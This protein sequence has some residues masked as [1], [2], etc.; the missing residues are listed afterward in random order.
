[1]NIVK[2]TIEQHFKAL[3]VPTFACFDKL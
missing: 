2:E 1:M 3:E